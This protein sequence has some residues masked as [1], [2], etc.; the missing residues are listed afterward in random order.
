MFFTQ[1][2]WPWSV[3]ILV[4]RLRVSHRA[5]EVSSEQVANTRLSM[6][7]AGEREKEKESWEMKV[8]PENKNNRQNRFNFL[9][10]KGKK[11]REKP[12]VRIA[13]TADSEHK[14]NKQQ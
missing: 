3:R 1:F 5:T 14:H 4:F 11:V 7:L 12:A 2:E 8:R 10:S 9:P 13:K 6:N